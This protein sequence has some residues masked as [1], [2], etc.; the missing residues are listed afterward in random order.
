MPPDSRLL[1]LLSIARI[2]SCLDN[3]AVGIRDLEFD[4][5]CDHTA[6]PDPH[7]THASTASRTKGLSYWDISLG[8]LGG[9]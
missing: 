5:R 2:L 1:G 4:Y 7:G 3:R 9:L 6:S 8:W